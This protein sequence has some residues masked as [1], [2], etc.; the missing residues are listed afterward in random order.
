MKVQKAKGKQSK[1]FA[2]MYRVL[3]CT[4]RLFGTYDR[5]NK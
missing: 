3:F 5:K 1:V 2:E 4:E